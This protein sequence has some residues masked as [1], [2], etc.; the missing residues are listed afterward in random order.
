MR[1]SITYAFGLAIFVAFGSAIADQ[2]WYGEPRLMKAVIV[3]LFVG[4][5][6]AAFRHWKD[7][8]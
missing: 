2:L 8:K 4:I 6:V 7:N 3:G 1:N 5:G